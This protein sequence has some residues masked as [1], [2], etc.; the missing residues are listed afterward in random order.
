MPVNP[1]KK[2]FQNS[3]D[4]WNFE[5]WASIG[6]S[7]LLAEIAQNNKAS[8]ANGRKNALNTKSFRMLSTPS[9]TTYMFSIQKIKNVIAGPVFK[10][11]ESGNICGIFSITGNHTLLIW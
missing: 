4:V 5:G 7:P 9:F 10:L 6:P 8:A 2:N 11:N 1:G 3:P